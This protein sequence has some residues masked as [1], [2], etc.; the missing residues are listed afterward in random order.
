MTGCGTIVDMAMAIR[1]FVMVDDDEYY[2][3][4]HTSMEVV[5]VRFPSSVVCVCPGVRE[6]F[7]M[8]VQTIKRLFV[9]FLYCSPHQTNVCMTKC[10]SR[11]LP[12]SFLVLQPKCLRDKIVAL[13][14]A[15]I[16]F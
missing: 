1:S 15:G 6:K 14:S 5:L 2:V 8:V 7:A 12:V 3:R 16:F 11:L 13:I 4:Y 10:S 9:T